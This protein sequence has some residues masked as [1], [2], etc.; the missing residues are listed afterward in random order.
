M[1]DTPFFSVLDDDDGLLPGALS[2]RLDAF[3]SE[4]PRPTSSSPAAIC[5]SAGR[6]RVDIEDFRPVEADPLR[7]LFVQ[8][9]LRPCAGCFRTAAVTAAFFESIPP[10]REWTWLALRW[11]SSSGSA[12]WPSRPSCTGP[13][14]PAR[15]P[16]RRPTLW[17][18]RP[19]SPAC[20]RWI[21]LPTC[22]PSCGPPGR[23]SAQCRRVSAR[24]RPPCGGLASAPR[25]LVQP[26]GWR[27]LP[28]A[29][30]RR[31]SRSPRRGRRR[32]ADCGVRRRV[33]ARILL[34]GIDAG[35]HAELERWVADGTLPTLGAL[36]RA[37]WWERTES[38]EGF[39]VGPTWPS[40]STGASP[41]EHGM[42]SL[43]QLA[44]GTYELRP[45]P[46]P[47]PNP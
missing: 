47:V 5:R 46:R 24:C 36:S 38:P 23:R 20:S 26:S 42:H 40:F 29:R 43:V 21:C 30:I 41:A 15:C 4:P 35:H 32:R 27:Y 9:W 28:Y 45:R 13:T 1:V 12:S 34:L 3:V 44:P 25:S 19:R 16:S 31:R 17:R 22:G 8:H 14:R 18:D 10:Y 39:F 7:A 37:D 11:R 2:T 33:S 6:R